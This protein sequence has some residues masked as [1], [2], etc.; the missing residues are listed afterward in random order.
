MV[1]AI[2]FIPCNASTIQIAVF[3]KLGQI[4]LLW[5]FTKAIYTTTLFLIMFQNLSP[6]FSMYAF[7][8]TFRLS[9]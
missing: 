6:L 9:N 1:L 3:L 5:T 8:H 4:R 7:L 2:V